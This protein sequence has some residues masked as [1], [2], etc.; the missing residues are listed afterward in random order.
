M[1]RSLRS[2]L[3]RIPVEREVDEE[4]AFHVEMRTRELTAAGMD[5]ERARALA[6]R[7]LAA[8]R[9]VRETCVDIGTKRDRRIRLMQWLEEFRQDVR[10]AVRQLAAAPAF[11][12]VAVLTLALGIGANSAIFALV[13]ATLLRPLP[14]PDPDRLVQLWERTDSTSRGSVAPLNAADWDA[15]NHTFDRIGG[16]IPSVG[17]MVMAGA[18]GNAETVP[19]QWVTHGI[20]D[21]LGLT[22]VAGRTF[23]PRDRDERANVVV[24]SEEFWRARFGG[25]PAIIGQVLRLDGDPYTVVGVMPREAEIIG[26][27]SIWALFPVGN[28]PYL[29]SA[30]FLHVIGRLAPGV[31]RDAA[32]T[33]LASIAA[34][35]AAEHPDTNAGRSVSLEPLHEAVVGR[36]LRVTSLLF[37]GVVGF[38]LL[39]CCANVANL[40]MAR[41]TARARELAIRSALGAGRFRVARQLLTESLV[42]SVAGGLLGLGAGATI[43]ATAPSLLPPELLPATMTPAFD[44][45]VVV[46]CAMAAV[47]VGVVFGLAPVWQSTT[48]RSA[49]TM[50]SDG[51]GTTGRGSRLRGLLVAGE[52]ATAVLLLFGAGLL[53]RTLVAVDTVDRG[54]RAGSVLTMMVDPLGGRYPTVASLVGFYDELETEIAAVPGVARVGWASTQPMGESSLGDVTYDVVGAPV[55]DASQRPAAD[56]QVASAGYFDAVDLP[57]VEGRAFTDH[58]TET[59]E[60]VCLVNEALARRHF[61]DRSPLGAQLAIRTS[62][63]PD[64]PVTLRRIVGVARQVKARPDEL[65]P[66]MQIYVPLGQDPTDDIFV[67]VRPESGDAGVLAGAVRA[68]IG[69]VDRDQLV[70]VRDVATL[71]D[72]ATVATSAHRF[73]AVLVATFAVLALLLAMVGVFGILSY[74]VQQRLREIAVRRA[75]GATTRDVVVLVVRH[76]AGVIVA[77]VVVGLA[78][79]ALAGRALAALLFGVRPLD[80]ATFAAVVAALIVTSALAVA[81]PAWRA[82]RVDPATAFRL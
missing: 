18:D 49:R 29:R 78:G 31:T 70:S 55:T 72:V 22:P 46:F 60:A 54:Y 41:A 58:D 7:R 8:L 24:L 34:A 52:V 66:F 2:W 71:G 27:S 74:A 25:D 45:R 3:W 1:K 48:T 12:L 65:E 11:S 63:A 76:A 62:S 16:Y 44:A 79:A 15:R 9:A 68:A 6:T 28:D 38:V 23:Q 47:V 77:G 39:I 80:P 4:L 13:D 73:R 21:A 36:D 59:S 53:L 69:R 35:M 26:R 67:F 33:D 43:L 32:A 50:A 82:T 56:Y 40:L 37:L 17:G 64:A 10:F 42:L 14:F 20:F 5:P 61:P 51:R 19:R 81:G 30:R 57:I 75:L